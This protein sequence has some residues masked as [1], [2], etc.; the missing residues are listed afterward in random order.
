MLG[1]HAQVFQFAGL[2]DDVL[3]L[4]VFVALDDV[5]FDHGRRRLI[6]LHRAL[7]HLL[8]A[9]ALAGGAADLVEAELA[10]AFSG[11]VQTDAEL[12]ERN[13]DL[14]GPIRSCHA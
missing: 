13:L 1:G 8:V 12:N 10:F 6:A 11:R 2:D 9:D 14:S 7:Q 3:A 5:V 4:A